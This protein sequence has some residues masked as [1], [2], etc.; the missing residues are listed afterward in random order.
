MAFTY[1]K[2][3]SDI[4]PRLSLGSVRF[5]FQG[6]VR[7]VAVKWRRLACEGVRRLGALSAPR[8]APCVGVAKGRRLIPSALQRCVWIDWTGFPSDDELTRDQRRQILKKQAIQRLE[9]TARSFFF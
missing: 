2:R 6:G 4:M 9:T 8:D 3:H 1:I 5:I 7:A